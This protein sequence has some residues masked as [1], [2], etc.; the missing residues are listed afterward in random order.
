MRGR[1]VHGNM[2]VVSTSTSVRD[3]SVSADKDVN[4]LQKKI[5]CRYRQIQKSPTGV[6]GFDYF[7]HQ[8]MQLAPLGKYLRR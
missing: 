7:S 2:D 6:F 3:I 1:G 4:N 8:R 5:I